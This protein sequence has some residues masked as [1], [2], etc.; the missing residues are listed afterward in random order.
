MAASPRV[1]TRVSS[2]SARPAPTPSQPTTRPVEPRPRV[3]RIN[4][5]GALVPVVRR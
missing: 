1:P 3:F 5:F 4:A 2:S